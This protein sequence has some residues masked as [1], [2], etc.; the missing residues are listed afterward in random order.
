[1]IAWAIPW[2]LDAPTLPTTRHLDDERRLMEA[3]DLHPPPGRADDHRRLRRLVRGR[4]RDEDHWDGLLDV[5]LT[6]AVLIRGWVVIQDGDLAEAVVLVT[7]AVV[8]ALRRRHLQVATGLVC[9][10][11]VVAAASGADPTT[12]AVLTCAALFSAAMH[13]RARSVLLLA[14]VVVVVLTPTIAHAGDHATLLVSFLTITTWTALALGLGHA[15][16]ANRDYVLALEHEAAAVQAARA[17]ETARHI[18]DERLRIA[19]DLH[20]AVA[21][22]IAAINVQAGAAE[23]HLPTDHARAQAA[24]QQ[25]R[26]T[27]RTVLLELRDI[28]AVLRSNQT[29]EADVTGRA[30][31]AGVPA[32]V[33]EAV[34]RGD[35]VRAD[36]DIDLDGLEPAVGAALYRVVQE[37]LTNAH[38]HG[39]SDGHTTVTITGDDHQ[40]AVRVVN[41]VAKALSLPTG[42]YGLVG[43][44]ER[45][46]Q[47]GGR[48]ETGAGAGSFSVRAWMPRTRHAG[49]RPGETAPG[50]TW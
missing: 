8:L 47:V 3:V 14:T 2:M 29:A 38:R 12:Y 50:P 16:R 11:S 41:P 26:S 32:L 36:L 18:T 9:T 39:D 1:M 17:S 44:R 23:R 15:A 22:S 7:I 24:L 25:V 46:E 40:V 28:V 27:S 6:V 30:S 48:L 21:H 35:L 5:A 4:P 10:L 45:V 20:D 31:A 49:R 19:R 43:M 34:G 37:A 33:D 42:G 13:V